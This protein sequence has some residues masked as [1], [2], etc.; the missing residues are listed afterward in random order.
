MNI[1]DKTNINI[2]GRNIVIIG[3]GQ[4]GVAAGKLA[5]YLGANVL[6]SESN[7]NSKIISLSKKIE[8]YGIDTELG[9]HSEKIFNAD[10]WVVSPGVPQD[11]SIIKKASKHNISI[12]SEIEFASWFTSS[13]IIAITGSNGKT[14]TVNLLS[15]IHI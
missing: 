11:I 4:S 2:K 3:I 15:L 8:S 1:T 7:S 12:V 10:L 13:Q 14:T 9:G 6:I 5:K